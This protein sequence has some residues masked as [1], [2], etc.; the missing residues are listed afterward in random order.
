MTSLGVLD[1]AYTSL[2]CNCLPHHVTVCGRNGNTYPSS[3]LAR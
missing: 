1:P 2:P 3:C